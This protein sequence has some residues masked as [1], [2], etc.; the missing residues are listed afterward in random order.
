MYG[1]TTYPCNAMTNVV[2]PYLSRTVCCPPSRPNKTSVVCCPSP[3]IPDHIA[4]R[5]ESDRIASLHGPAKVRVASSPLCGLPTVSTATILVRPGDTPPYMPVGTVPASTTTSRKQQQ[6][7]EAPR[8]SQY[9]PPAPIPY[10]RPM[11]YPSN[12][13]KPSV[14]VCLPIRRFTGIPTPPG[15]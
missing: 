2:I 7:V 11:R 15:G 10:C 14:N 8:F 13:S 12:D 6:A 9:F 1:R 4:A 5:S 3:P